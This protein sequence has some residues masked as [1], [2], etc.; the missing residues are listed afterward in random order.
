MPKQCLL[1]IEEKE[2]NVKNI[3]V[4]MSSELHERIKL[5]ATR[6]GLSISAYIRMVA[7]DAA[8]NG[9]D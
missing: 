7:A 8:Q 4:K 6:K 9:G 5:A 1:V 3:Q 2:T